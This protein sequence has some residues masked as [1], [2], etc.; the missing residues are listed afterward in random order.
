MFDFGSWELILVAVIAIF[1]IGP[2]ELPATLRTL[3]SVMR[4]AHNLSVMFRGH[5]DDM[6]REA[7]MEELRDAARD[8]KSGNFGKIVEDAVDPDYVMRDSLE[9]V[10][11]MDIPDVPDHVEIPQDADKPNP[12][13]EEP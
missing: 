12:P 7:E 8:V 6:V 13:R 1:V 10:M 11:D 5:V 3:G 4:K 9:D 2:K